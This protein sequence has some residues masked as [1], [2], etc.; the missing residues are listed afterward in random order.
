[1][2][3][4]SLFLK[5]VA[6]QHEQEYRVAILH[7]GEPNNTR[8]RIK[9]NPHVLVRAVMMDPRAPNAIYEV[10]RY[11]LKEKIGFNGRVKQSSLYEPQSAQVPAPP[12]L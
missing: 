12:I 11:Y 3:L 2:I 1:M 10:M 7:S 6:F 5:R 4:R 8:L 9:V